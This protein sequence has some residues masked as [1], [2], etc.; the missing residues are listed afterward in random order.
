[1]TNDEGQL[2]KY[3]PKCYTVTIIQL[4]PI[5]SAEI[6]LCLCLLEY[7]YEHFNM[8]RITCTTR[9]LLKNKFLS[10][11]SQKMMPVF[12]I[13]VR[14]GRR[15]LTMWRTIRVSAQ[16]DILGKTATSVNI[17]SLSKFIMNTHETCLFKIISWILKC[18]DW[19][20][21][22]GKDS[23]NLWSKNYKCSILFRSY[24][25]IQTSLNMARSRTKV[26][27]HAQYT[28]QKITNFGPNLILLT[29]NACIN[30]PCL[31][32]A[33][34]NAVGSTGYSCTCTDAYMGNN[35]DIG[36]YLQVLKPSDD[37][38]VLCQFIASVVVPNKISL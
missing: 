17:L 33:T 8:E 13:H 32:G 11:P 24:L 22:N 18:N 19:S 1:M 28:A 16:L 30:F 7:N 20:S 26:Y 10:F 37:I 31:N 14:M 5:L 4:R 21:V 6:E 27:I 3:W 23:D 2:V 35:C 38:T 12:P 34:C 25:Y 29:V 15:A 36:K 9:M